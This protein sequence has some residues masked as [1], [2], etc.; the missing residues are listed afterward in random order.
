MRVFA[1]LL[2]VGMA[3]CAANE[4][5]AMPARGPM[6]AESQFERKCQREGG[7]VVATQPIAHD[8]DGKSLR[9]VSDLDQSRPRAEP[10]EK[11]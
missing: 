1:V 5:T 8:V 4:A 10:T 3:G 9:C 6:A 11:P 7:H 2:L